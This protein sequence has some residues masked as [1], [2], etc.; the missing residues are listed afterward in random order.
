MTTNALASA[1]AVAKETE[2]PRAFESFN[3]LASTARTLTQDLLGMQKVFKEITKGRSELE[4]PNQTNIQV[5]GDVNVS[6]KQSTTDIIAALQDA[7][8]SG[9]ITPLSIGG[10]DG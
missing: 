2:H 1:L 7:I 6:K 5:N 9:G 3:S 8:N 10:I 4:P